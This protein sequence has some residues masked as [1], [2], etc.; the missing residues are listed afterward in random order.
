MDDFDQYKGLDLIKIV[1]VIIVLLT[2]ISIPFGTFYRI[3]TGKGGILTNWDG[4]KVAI[5]GVG[6]HL[7]TPFLTDIQISSIVNNNIY[8]PEDYLDLEAKFQA[9]NQ[10]GAIG[11]DIKTT[12]DKVVDTGAVM[13]YEI[14]DLFQFGVKNTNPQQQL[15][16][17]F[18]A[19]VFNYLQ[20]QSSDNI[21]SHVTQINDDLL[22]KLRQ[23]DLEKQFG[24][25]INSMSLLRPTFTKVALDALAEKQAIQ[26]KSEGDLNAAKNQALAI[27][28]IAQAQKNQADI[29]K[30]IPQEQ[31]DFNAKLAL[32]NTLKGQNNVIWVIPSG[33]PIVLGQPTGTISSATNTSK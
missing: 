19:V 15:Q 21:T 20:S 24:I 23:S 16:K 3:D 26:A 32:Y 10:A 1:G 5:T 29:L 4:S 6:W 12:D 22:Q 17:E 30:N 7:R 9:D 8:F 31:L 13:A 25:K 14:T 18:D 2:L 11:F 28:T 33:Q 27:E